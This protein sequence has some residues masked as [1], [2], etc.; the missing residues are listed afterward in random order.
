VADGGSVDAGERKLTRGIV[1]GRPVENEKDGAAPHCG[2]K[3][4]ARTW[5]LPAG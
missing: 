2:Y 4:R 5:R 3:V 1:D